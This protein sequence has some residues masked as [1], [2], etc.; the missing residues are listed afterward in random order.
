MCGA[1]RADNAVCCGEPATAYNLRATLSDR[2]PKVQIGAKMDFYI[3]KKILYGKLPSKSKLIHAFLHT[4]TKNGQNE[5]KISDA[6]PFASIKTKATFLK[7]MN[8]L[9]DKGLLTA[10]TKGD[11]IFF[12]AYEPK[13]VK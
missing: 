3:H 11:K 13:D 8:I 12:I 4:L 9:I 7:Y 10:M 6:M 5:A 2:N 1:N